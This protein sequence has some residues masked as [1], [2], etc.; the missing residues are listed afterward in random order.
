MS[1]PMTTPALLPSDRPPDT[2]LAT[3][4]AAASDM[5]VDA[6]SPTLITN[7]PNQDLAGAKTGISQQL[8]TY[9][10]A[11][12]GPTSLPLT[13]NRAT[14]WTPVGEHDLIPGQKDGEPALTISPDFKSKICA[15]WQRTLVVR[16]LGAKIGFTTL[17]SRLRALWRP[18]GALEIRDI[19]YDCF[20]V[21]LDNEQDYFRALTD[22]PWLIF[23]HYLVVQQWSPSFKVSDPLPKTMIVWAQLPALKIHFYHREVL[24]TLGNLIGRTIKLD[25]HTLTQQRA[26]FARIA[27]E[28]DLSKHLVPRI[29]LDDGWQKVEYENLPE[30]CFECG[31]IGHSADSCPLLRLPQVTGTT[32]I[33]GGGAGE[34]LTAESPEENPGFGPWML[35]SRKSRRHPRDLQRKGNSDLDSMRSSQ[36][37]SARNGKVDAANG[38]KE[39]AKQNGEKVHDVSAQRVASQER[40]ETNGKKSNEG[41]RKGKEKA[42][43]ES[44]SGKGLLGAGPGRKQGTPSGPHRVE[45]ANKAS[46]SGPKPSEGAQP[47]KSAGPSNPVPALLNPTLPWPAPL[48]VH[49][50]IGPNGTVLQ[51]VEVTDSATPSFT[52]AGDE[53]PPVTAR[54]RK[55]K[56]NQGTG[57]EGIAGQV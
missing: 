31:K 2:S 4:P 12:S 55:S 45:E 40:K 39:R 7:E 9:A 3:S 46:T 18:A 33:S 6:S 24:T 15:P 50:T 28:V 51:I 41:T 16:L 13:S 25:Y 38:E 35:V 42:V 37:N 57:T 17:C 36:G 30:V 21:K 56:K 44:G 10:K 23:D 48:A 34:A 26:K 52:S 47:T 5:I 32:T 19:D 11:L 27:V 53:A 54:A 14:T 20:L 8:F 43:V 29:W 49:S 22:G 1:E